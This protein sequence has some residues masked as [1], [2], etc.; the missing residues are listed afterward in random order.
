MLMS[1]S[2]LDHIPL[3][4]DRLSTDFCVH[5]VRNTHTPLV[6]DR[7][8]TDFCVHT[9]RNTHTPLVS[10][11]LS[12]DFCVRNA[13]C[14]RSR[15][16]K[17]KP[18]FNQ[19]R[20]SVSNFN[21]TSVAHGL[22]RGEFNHLSDDD[23]QKLNRLMARIAETAYRRGA[24]HGAYLQEHGLIPFD[25][26]DWRFTRNLDSAPWLNGSRQTSIERLHIEH[27]ELEDIGFGIDATA[28]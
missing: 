18:F 2:I 27:P 12:T 15:K 25:L 8:S 10:D 9:V 4:S 14:V 13:V 22:A 28:T 1:A 7:L 5:T 24:Q 17:L 16:T 23:L 11:R 20:H 21:K 26:A 6:S 3:V 19:R